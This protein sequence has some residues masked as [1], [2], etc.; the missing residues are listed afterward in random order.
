VPKAL[1]VSF[2]WEGRKGLGG[3]GKGERRESL[4]LVWELKK[5]TRKGNRELM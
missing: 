4:P 1:F 2:E 5:P 3:E